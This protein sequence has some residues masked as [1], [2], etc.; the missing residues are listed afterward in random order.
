MPLPK[1]PAKASN[2]AK[3]ASPGGSGAGIGPPQETEKP[4]SFPAKV[5]PSPSVSPDA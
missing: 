1:F 3:R 4:A 5:K 2:S